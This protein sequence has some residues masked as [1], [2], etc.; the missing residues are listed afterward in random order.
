MKVAPGVDDPPA[1]TDRPRKDIFIH[2]PRASSDAL[3][4]FLFPPGY[5]LYESGKLIDHADLQLAHNARLGWW[6]LK[7]PTGGCRACMLYPTFP[8]CLWT[9][10]ATLE[11]SRGE[12]LNGSDQPFTAFQMSW[13]EL[14]WGWWCCPMPWCLPAEAFRVGASGKWRLEDCDLPRPIA[15]KFEPSAFGSDAE[16]TGEMRSLGYHVERWEM[17]D[18]ATGERAGVVLA[19]FQFDGDGVGGALHLHVTPEASACPLYDAALSGCTRWPG[20]VPGWL[21]GALG[22]PCAACCC[23]L[24]CCPT[25]G[26]SRLRSVQ[27]TLVCDDPPPSARAARAALATLSRE[28]RD[29]GRWRSGVE[30]NMIDA[31]TGRA[32]KTSRARRPLGMSTMVGSAS[33][34][35]PVVAVMDD[36]VM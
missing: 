1:V 30:V 18:A 3:D 29:G 31:A 13:E 24:Y 28:R 8:A 27:R 32:G 22:G 5:N 10:E 14:A 6:R 11:V 7:E 12:A 4:A 34:R 33:V 17:R 15:G 23:C 2:A 21:C 25:V 35:A 16:W 19:E 36:Y 26:P 20:P 9:E